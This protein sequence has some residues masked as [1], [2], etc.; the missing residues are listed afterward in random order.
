MEIK[1][2]FDKVI[3]WAYPTI[4]EPKTDKLFETWKENKKEI[5]DAFGG[6]L[7][8]E[9]PEKVTFELDNEAKTRRVNQ[10][11]DYLE[12]CGYVD[13]SNFIHAQREGF[14]KNTVIEEYKTCNTKTPIITKN[15]KLVKAFKY[16]IDNEKELNELQSKASQ[17]IQE[18]KIEGTLC[19]SVHPL[20]YLSISENNYNWRSCHA[21]DGEYCAGNLS[22]MMDKSTVI[23]YLKGENEVKLPNFPEEVKWN[24]K[25]WRV[26]LYLANDWKMIYAGRQYPFST[27]TGMKLILDKC[28]NKNV[29]PHPNLDS[30]SK[31]GYRAKWSDW[32]D[33]AIK[34]KVKNKISD[35]MTIQYDLYDSYIPMGGELISLHNIVKDA[36]GSKHFNDVLKSSFYEPMYTQ[37]V[38]NGYWSNDDIYHSCASH[39][40]F[41][42]G[43]YTHCLRCGKEEVFEGGSTLMC[44]D[45]EL[46]YGD[47]ENDS[48]GFCS[49]CG[50]RIDMENAYWYEDEPYC[51]DC[52][53][54]MGEECDNCG[55]LYPTEEMLYDEAN[56]QYFCRWCT[57]EG[58]N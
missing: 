32:S 29:I 20:D 39:S 33:Y 8:Y 51:N 1:E 31:P 22:Y 40:R 35:T 2:Q 28:L 50:T 26:L 7:I 6:K 56:D 15:T 47:T 9:I 54:N 49:K 16:F 25:K 3:A 37:L 55:C 13:L 42:I 17:I 48:F 11:I 52:Y 41:T 27:D 19:F 53:H 34:N 45:C 21:L 4:G 58:R 43:A 23:C 30:W 24:N 46:K 18:N 57:E 44:Y 38:E 14:Y 12:N 10:F 36:E 5:I